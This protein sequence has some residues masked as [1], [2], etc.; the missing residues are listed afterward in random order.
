MPL[1]TG[2]VPGI[3]LEFDGRGTSL[4]ERYHVTA[5]LHTRQQNV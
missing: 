5:H 3:Y 2:Y 1:C 4:V